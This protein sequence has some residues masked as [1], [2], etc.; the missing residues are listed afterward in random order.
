VLHVSIGDNNETDGSTAQY[1][2][3]EFD[4]HKF[5][6]DDP[7]GER[8]CWTDYGQ[9][10]YAAV[11]YS[12]IPA[13]DGRRIWLGWTSN[14]KYPFE[15]PTK[16]WKGGMS[17]PRSLMLK[18]GTDG[19]IRLCQQPVKELQR[20][21]RSEIQYEALHIIDGSMK[22]DY[23]GTS[24]ELE[25]ELEWEDAV[26]IGLRVRVSEHESTVVGYET[27]Q[28]TL[29]IDRG[30]SGV[31]DLLNR[32]GE[33]FDFGK[34]FEALYP[35]TSRRI[36]LHAYIDDSII[37]LFVDNGE[38]VFTVLIYPQ[39]ESDGLELYAKGGSAL[40]HSVKVYPLKSIWNV[41]ISE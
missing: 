32:S 38:V 22:L 34:K 19:V 27:E 16:P 7:T 28:E 14:W 5:V 21:R 39:Q 17:I 15:G 13:S 35:V 23:H 10:F 6:N 30:R 8:I 40:F 12:D 31:S 41:G 36:K 11:S 18:T 3:G 20:L 33:P 2:V 9:D 25:A 37:E 26:E 1:F 24:Y 29:F 4:G